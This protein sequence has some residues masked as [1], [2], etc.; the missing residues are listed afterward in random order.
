LF[1][2]PSTPERKGERRRPADRIHPTAEA[3]PFGV[4]APFEI[5]RHV[6]HV[7]YGKPLRE[8][9]CVPGA[10]DSLE[11]GAG[12]RARTSEEARPALAGI[13]PGGGS[14]ARGGR[15]SGGDKL[16]RNMVSER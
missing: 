6:D 8:S 1:G 12:R 11:G 4:W 5:G 15:R 2:F 13:G 16:F 3:W 14:Y 9:C 10:G 7:F